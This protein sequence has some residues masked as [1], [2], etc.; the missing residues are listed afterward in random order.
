MTAKRYTSMDIA[1]AILAGEVIG[2]DEFMRASDYDATVSQH[3]QVI[4]SWK[5]EEL[6]WE[7][8][9]AALTAR[10]ERAE[11]ALLTERGKLEKADAENDRLQ[12]RVA[13]LES[14][15][16]AVV[17]R[18]DTPLWKDVGPT[19]DVIDAL[20]RALADNSVQSEQQSN[21]EAKP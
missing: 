3:T 20:R 2:T 1:D 6:A 13:E 4:A 15:A 16:R 12:A 10:C 8:E 7:A 9:I 14:A 5:R 19:A 18:W 21:P 17:A 11:Y